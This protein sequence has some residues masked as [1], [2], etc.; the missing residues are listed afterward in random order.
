MPPPIFTAAAFRQAM[1][2]LL[3]TGRIWP[4]EEGTAQA[5]VLNGLAP[6]YERSAAD[7]A[8][9][10]VNA[11]P[12]TALG[13]LREWEATLGLEPEATM[14]QRHGAVLAQLIGIGGQSVPV[15]TAYAAAMGISIGITQFA[16]ARAG[17]TRAGDPAQGE[18]WAFHW[19]VNS[20]GQRTTYARAGRTT[21]GEPLVEWGD[22]S[23]EIV[24][25]RI[26]A[27]H[28]TVT[29]NYATLWD[30][31]ATTWDGGTTAWDT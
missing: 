7:A 18:A 27:A 11:F 13:L 9:L 25:R 3:P 23:L 5:A 22:V 2:A 21:A 8:A 1:Q 15:I 30:A 10:L 6:V 31:G 28:T 17:F 4:R 16:P 26:A 20:A 24:L 12:I 29:F 19:Q 14:Q